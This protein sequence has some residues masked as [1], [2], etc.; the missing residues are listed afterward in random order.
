MK[1]LRLPAI[2]A[3]AIIALAASASGLRATCGTCEP[4]NDDEIYALCLLGCPVSQPGCS[5]FDCMQVGPLCANMGPC[6]S[7]HGASVHAAGTFVMMEPED[8]SHSPTAAVIEDNGVIV[9]RIRCNAVAVAFKYPELVEA[10]IAS[11]I[12]S[13]T[14]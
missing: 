5:M 13:I 12:Q 7:A 6:S 4:R 10:E 11:S 1:R 14:I 3:A 9:E 8:E 2:V